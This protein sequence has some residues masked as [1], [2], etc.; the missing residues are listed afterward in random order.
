M[1]LPR[2]V[3]RFSTSML[4]PGSFQVRATFASAQ[5]NPTARGLSVDCAYDMN[6]LEVAARCF[7]FDITSTSRNPNIPAS[8]LKYDISIKR[9]DI[10]I[11]DRCGAINPSGNPFETEPRS[12]C[13]CLHV[14]CNI[15]D[16]NVVTCSFQI[17]VILLWHEDIK[18]NI[19]IVLPFSAS[20]S[21]L[22]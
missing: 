2:R 12:E 9:L 19:E 20:V 8:R 17:K 22:L 16:R 6:D 5:C 11:P 13:L 3:C 10:Y 18:L 14:P 15:R 1:F 21:R 4:P 7:G